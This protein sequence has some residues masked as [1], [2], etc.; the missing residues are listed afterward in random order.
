MHSAVYLLTLFAISATQQRSAPM[1]MTENNKYFQSGNAYVDPPNNYT[2]LQFYVPFKLMFEE[3]EVGGVHLSMTY[4]NLSYLINT[5]NISF[6]AVVDSYTKSSFNFS[7]Y[8]KF[9]QY[10]PPFSLNYRYLI[11]T[12]KYANNY[13]W[14]LININQTVN[15]YNETQCTDSYHTIPTDIVFNTSGP[16]DQALSIM[17]FDAFLNSTGF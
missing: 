8:R 6:Y 5:T 13:N 15:L 12:T 2:S 7:F 10:T 4:Y 11:F 3:S 1:S 17:G 14:R 16:F 9:Y